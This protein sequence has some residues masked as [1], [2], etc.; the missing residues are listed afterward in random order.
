MTK[1]AIAPGGPTTTLT[2]IG[3]LDGVRAMSILLVLMGHM[4]PLSPKSW[5]FNAMAATTGMALFFCLSG[6]LIVSLLDR[7]ADAISFLI[8]RVFRILPP[9]VIYVFLMVLLFGISGRAVLENALF[10]TNYFNEG[11]GRGEVAAPMTHLWSLSVEMHFYIAMGLSAF[12]LGRRAIWLVPPA[13]IVVTYLRIEASIPV[14]I[15]THLRVDEILAGGILA[16]GSI[17]YGNTLR[18]L[19]SRQ[20]VAMAL[21]TLTFVFLL[22]S[23]HPAG[24]PIMYLRPYAAAAFVGCLLF[25][26]IGALHRALESRFAV[27]IARISYALYI[28]HPLMIW[29]TMNTGSDVERYLL[30]RPVSF[31]LTW[32]AAHISTFYWENLWQSY[33]RRLT[34][35]RMQTQSA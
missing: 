13:A 6:F 14:N 2:H 4:L 7:N 19:L 22:I 34:H 9:L 11:R 10:V 30:K 15:A 1:T 17:Y 27:Y 18:L 16:L 35:K 8:K 25:S 23:S 31:I 26:D 12:L 21:I 28:Y 3:T 20:R 29:G 32:V 5:E 33:A 24:G